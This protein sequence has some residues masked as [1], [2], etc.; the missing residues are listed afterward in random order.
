MYG[1]ARCWIEVNTLINAEDVDL[2]LVDKSSIS[3]AISDNND[4]DDDKKFEVN[5]SSVDR[6]CDTVRITAAPI[7][8][9]LKEHVY[10]IKPVFMLF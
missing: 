4:D 2:I 3:V 10:F 1:P 6:D 5:S 7:Y 8:S 9:M